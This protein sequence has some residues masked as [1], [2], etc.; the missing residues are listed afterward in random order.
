MVNIGFI[1]LGCS[2]NR[3]DTEIMIAALKRSGEKIVDSLTRADLIIIN[4][5]GFITAAK[6]EAINTIIETG[7]LKQDGNLKYLIATGCLAQRY[8]SELLDELPELDAVV[9]ISTFPR[10]SQVINDLAKGERL[11]YIEPPA[12]MFI[13][14]GPRLLTTPKGAAYLKISEGCNNHCAYCAIPSIR[15]QLRSRPIDELAEEARNLVKDGVREISV[16]AQDTAR[17]GE[18]LRDGSSLAA[19]LSSLNRV[20]GLEWIRLMYVHPARITSQLIESIAEQEK[21]IPYLDIP[22]QHASNKILAAMNRQHTIETCKS[23]LDQ[24]KANIPGLVLRT[25]VMTGFPG[26]TEEDFNQLLNFVKEM[27]FEWLGTFCFE[28]EEGTAAFHMQNQIPDELK[29]ERRDR[30]MKLQ[31]RIT[32]KKNMLRVGNDEKILISSKIAG[33]LY[34]GRGY[35]QAPEVDGITMVKSNNKLQ[36]GEFVQVKLQGVREYDMIGELY[37]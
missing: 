16:I 7:R 29:Q 6:E 27:E 19:L 15:G 24:L 31:K 28:P 18:D 11:S 1:S 14:K 30:I 2:K 26:E 25:T 37:I 21:V 3:V 34:A 23:S 13:E 12:K 32:R 20:E 35:Y 10:I 4:T 17:Y 33:N 36:P 9:G 8:G 22:I 5:C